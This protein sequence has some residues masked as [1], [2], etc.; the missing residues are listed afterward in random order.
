MR[1]VINDQIIEYRTAQNKL[2]CEFCQST[3]NPHVDHIIHF[4]KLMKDFIKENKAPETF[5]HECN[6]KIRFRQEDEAFKTKW[7]QYHRENATL[8]I[9]CAKCN[10]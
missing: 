5:L 4:E 10:T 2:V 1:N 8:R 9:L 6:K 7:Q 3:D